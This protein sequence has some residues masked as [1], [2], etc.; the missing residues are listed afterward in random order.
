MAREGRMKSAR[1]LAWFAIAAQVAFVAAWI[2]A[3]ALQDGYSYIDH[4]V[5]DLGAD[6]GA[7]PWIVNTAIVVLGLGVAAGVVSVGQ[8]SAAL[9]AAALTIAG[10]AVGAR[11]FPKPAS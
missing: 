8:S 4:H 5:S 3:G 10:S 1:A 7:H 9:A 6:G 11:V 2:V